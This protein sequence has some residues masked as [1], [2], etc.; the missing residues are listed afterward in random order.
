MGSRLRLNSLKKLA[1]QWEEGVV[2]VQSL[3]TCVHDATLSWKNAVREADQARETG[4]VTM[5]MLFAEV[6]GY[7]RS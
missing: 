4:I 7:C 5:R 3:S 6:G 2:D 1:Q